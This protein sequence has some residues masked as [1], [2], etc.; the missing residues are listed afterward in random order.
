MIGHQLV[1][2]NSRGSGTAG[3]ALA[4]VPMLLLVPRCPEHAIFDFAS[5]GVFLQAAPSGQE[6]QEEAQSLKIFFSI[7]LPVDIF[8]IGSY[9]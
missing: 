4:A 5:R 2:V 1:K 6:H 8:S 9:L 3:W 7:S